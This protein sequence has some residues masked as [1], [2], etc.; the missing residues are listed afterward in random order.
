[1]ARP[2]LASTDEIGVHGVA[3]SLEELRL[4]EARL[5]RRHQRQS[6]L[7]PR[8]RAAVRYIFERA[9]DGDPASPKELADHLGISQSAVTALATRLVADGIIV[10]RVHTS[11]G[12][13]KLLVP[14]NR[15]DHIDGQDPLT[16]SIRRAVAE[17]SDHEAE[18]VRD[19][20]E[21]LR[22]IVDR[23]GSDASSTPTPDE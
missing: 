12:R 22:D 14:M 4:A 11:D 5:E 6:T 3:Q 23:A 18:I 21:N 19:F 17:L 20:L 15:N 7:A 16:D 1:M 2:E 8:D 13:R 10:T 9:D